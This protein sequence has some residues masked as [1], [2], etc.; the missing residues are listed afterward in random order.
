M[1]A[2]E[3]RFEQPVQ[4]ATV[5]AAPTP[6]DAQTESADCLVMLLNDPTTPMEFVI[7]ILENIFEKTYRQSM[8]IMLDTHKKGA[9]V[10]GKYS[11]AVAEWKTA[12]VSRLAK[13]KNHP[14][15]CLVVPNSPAQATQQTA[16]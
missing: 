11:R 14:L 8:D 9:G 4:P 2:A 13:E 7:A 15:Q 1:M 3:T 6:A 12:E 16:R 5:P 10:C